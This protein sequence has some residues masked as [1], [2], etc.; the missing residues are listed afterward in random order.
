MR[1]LFQ[2]YAPDIDSE[3]FIAPEAVVI[4]KV[5][6]GKDS[7]V[8]PA[9]VVRGDMNTITIGEGTSIQDGC[10]LHN[11]FEDP[12]VVGSYVTLGHQVILHSC[13]V[14]D[15]CLIGMGAII[16]DRAKISKNSIVAAG[17]LVTS[18]KIFPEGSMIMGSPAKVV[19][20]LSQEEIDSLKAHAETYIQ[21]AKAHMETLKPIP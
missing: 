20:S 1:Y 15:N 2:D 7:S 17:S 6:I 19:R 10:I 18:G 14:E 11:T 5:T 9:A 12:L 16:L 8:W 21:L 4:G 3:A 13:E